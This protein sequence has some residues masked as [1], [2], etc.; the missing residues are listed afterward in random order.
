[1]VKP[2]I[3]LNYHVQGTACW[4]MMRAMIKVQEY[5][6]SLGD[7]YRLVMNVHDEIVVEMPKKANKGNLPKATRIRELMESIGD[8]VGV[9]LTCGMDY[10][11]NYW[12]Q[13]C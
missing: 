11:P 7:G 13:A 8:C 10:H 12:S 9:T 2:T 1:M 3:P 4:V 6:D 5:L